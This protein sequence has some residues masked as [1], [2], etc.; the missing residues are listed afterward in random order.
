MK[1][2]NINSFLNGVKNSLD[3]NTSCNTKFNLNEVPLAIGQ[4]LY[5]MDFKTKKIVFQKGVFELLGYKPHE[6]TFETAL[7]WYHPKDQELLNRL[8]NATVLYSRENNVS[9]NVGYYVYARIKHKN[10][11]YVKILCKSNIYEFDNQG[12]L[13]STYSLL[14]DISFLD[15]GDKVQWVF[16]AHGLDSNRFKKYVLKEF[17]GFFTDRELEVLKLLS[18]GLTS[19]EISKKLFISK[20]TVDGHRRNMLKKTNCNNSIELINFSKTNAF[21]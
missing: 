11:D 1:K 13:I 7:N 3:Q 12:K 5:A 17:E 6:F 4:C 21:I 8:L 14:T 16:K 15:V 19:T 18:I 10:G 2:N 20:H 9:N